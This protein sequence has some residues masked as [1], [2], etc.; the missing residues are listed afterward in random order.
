V[1]IRQESPAEH[2]AVRSLIARAFAGRPFSDGREPRIVDGLRRADALV[3]SLVAV[4]G[5]QVVGHVAFSAVGPPARHGWYALG[6]VSVEP[7][8]QRRGVGTQLIEAGL[9]DLRSRGA[10]GC[11]VGGDHR[12][13][14]RFG[15]ALVPEL[16]PPEYSAE[17]F[18]LLAFGPSRPLGRV[19]FH[20]AFSIGP[21]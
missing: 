15:F 19:A 14:Q 4:M 11:V 20:P 13:Y 12:Y 21:S 7:S 9:R 5:S 10:K 1:L 3:L 8:F 2:D 16:A 18:Q 6:P 17:H